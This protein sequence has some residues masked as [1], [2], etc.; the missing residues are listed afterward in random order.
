MEHRRKQRARQHREAHQ[1]HPGDAIQPPLQHPFVPQNE[2]AL[3]RD[4]ER[5][6]ELVHHLRSKPMFA[7]DTEFI[8]E[9]TYFPKTCLVQVA[10]EEQV[11]LI[12]PF[13]IRDLSAIWELVA[14]P[15]RITIV[16][17][18]ASDLSPVRRALGKEPEGVIDVQVAAGFLGMNYPSSLGKLVERFAGHPLA[19]GHTFTDWDARPLSGQQLRYAADDVRYLPLLWLQMGRELEKG[20]R[21]PWAYRETVA[22]LEDPHLFDAKVH[23]RRASRGYDLTAAQERLLEALCTLRDRIALEMD[24]PH[25]ATVPDGSLLE[26]V[27]DRPETKEALANVRGM[28]RPLVVRFGEKFLDVLKA[29]PSEKTEWFAIRKR[30]EDEQSIRERV[31]RMLA[32]GHARATELGIATTM[33]LTRGD[34][35]RHSRRRRQITERGEDPPPVFDEGDWRNEAF[36]DAIDRAWDG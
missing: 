24:Q 6:V 20:G 7:F 36:G 25:R 16:H 30:R 10:T 3:I 17:A 23:M 12:D 1:A 14:D 8:G 2:P 29:N 32:A 34:L 11:A 13:A 15:L 35:E 33:A 28:P 27:R 21:L 18:G 5:Y 19:K 26:M 22:R 4:Q 31:D 9:V